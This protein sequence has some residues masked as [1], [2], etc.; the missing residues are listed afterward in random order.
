MFRE[1]GRGQRCQGAMFTRGRAGGFGRGQGREL[2]NAK[3]GAYQESSRRI[4]RRD[5]SCLDGY[6]G[7][8]NHGFDGKELLKNK[9][10]FLKERIKEIDEI[11]LENEEE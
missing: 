2:A 10:E 3:S 11:L 9:K 7:F 4:R 6:G 5:F 8:Y 1:F